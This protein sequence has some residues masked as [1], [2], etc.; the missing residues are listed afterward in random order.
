MSRCG[1]AAKTSVS[2]TE[3]AGSSPATFAQEGC[4]ACNGSGGTWDGERFDMTKT[5]LCVQEVAPLA[6]D[7]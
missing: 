5:C 6:S 7:G 3:D 2:K 1:L 4:G